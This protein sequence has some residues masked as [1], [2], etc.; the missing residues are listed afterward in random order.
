M[1]YASCARFAKDH[2][3]SYLPFA[4]GVYRA[5]CP[6]RPARGSGS[7]NPTTMQRPEIRTYEH[8]IHAIDLGY[9]RPGLAASHLIVR[10]GRAAFV[11]TGPNG[12][13]PGCSP[14]SMRWGS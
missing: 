11:D 4:Y 3:I 2:F 14:P 13:V 5:R 9:I 8:G 10:A 6:R 7:G 12:S 1:Y